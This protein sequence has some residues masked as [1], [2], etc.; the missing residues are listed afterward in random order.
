MVIAGIK[1]VPETLKETSGLSGS[2]ELRLKMALSAPVL[3]GENL[4]V[5][6]LE[7]KGAIV[8]GKDG[9]A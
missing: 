6:C 4:I 2:F 8:K 9:P 3:S 1:P 7:L 5:N